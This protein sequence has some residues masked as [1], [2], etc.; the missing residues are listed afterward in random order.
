MRVVKQT[1][2]PGPVDAPAA[3]TRDARE[4][5]ALTLALVAFALGL[6]PAEL[7]ALLEVGLPLVG[8]G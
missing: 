7:V 1:F 2:A 6:R 8:G 3:P 4:A 5:V